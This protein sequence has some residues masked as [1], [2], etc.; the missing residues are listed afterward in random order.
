[1]EQLRKLL[2]KHEG[3]RLRPYRCTA[4]KLTIGVGRNLEEVG[5][6][7][8][9]ASA[10]LDNDIARVLLELRGLEFFAAL[11]EVRRAVLADMCFNLGFAGLGKFR[12]MLAAVETGDFTAAS[13][14]MLNS[15]W[16]VQVGSRAQR[17]SAMMKTG[18]W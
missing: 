7:E 8:A 12:K 17:L 1:M 9:E 2:I 15:R 11:D 6:T 4:G 3:L 5:I 14:E 16:A 13:A 10:M 18:Q